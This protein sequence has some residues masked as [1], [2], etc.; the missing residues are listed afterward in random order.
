MT[1]R[2]WGSVVLVCMVA[3][4]AFA[5]PPLDKPAFT[6]TAAELQS[7]AKAAVRG[8]EDTVLLREDSEISYDERG[9]VTA[10]WRLV[11]VVATQ[12][13]AADWNTL[14]SSWLPSHQDK[15]TVRARVIDVNGRVFDLDPSLITDEPYGTPTTAQRG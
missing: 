13:G 1:G 15:P 10:R 6:A 3:S 14:T 8:T 4:V 7:V 11:F 9:R 12:A 2:L 5:T